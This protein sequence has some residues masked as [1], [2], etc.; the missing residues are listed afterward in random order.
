MMLRVRED[1]LMFKMGRSD[2]FNGEED[3]RNYGEEE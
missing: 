1:Y 3:V 2:S